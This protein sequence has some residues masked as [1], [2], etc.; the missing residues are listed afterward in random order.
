M[1]TAVPVIQSMTNYKQ[2]Q[3][4]VLLMD[5]NPSLHLQNPNPY[6]ISLMSTAK[7]LLSFPQLSSSLFSFKP[8]FSSLSPLLSSSR[9]SI[10]SLSLSFNPPNTTL[11]SLS[12]FLTS[13][14]TTTDK[15]SIPSSSPRAL[16]LSASLRQLVHDY[17]WD[18]IISDDGG[19]HSLS[20]TLL[21]CVKPNLVVLFSPIIRSLNGL[22]EFFDMELSDA[23]EFVDKFREVFQSV[24][25]AFVSKGIHFSWVD[26]KYETGCDDAFDESGVFESG[27]RDL[28]WGICSSDCIVL[29]SALLPFGLIYPRI[30]ISPK[31]VNFDDS[32]KPIHAQ[33]ILEILDVNGKPL[34]CKCCDLELVN[35]NIFSAITSKLIWEDFRHGIIKLHVKAVQNSEKCV[36]FDGFTLSNPVIVRELSG[37]SGGQKE[38][39][40][41]FFEDRVLEILGVQL[42]ELVP[43]KSI[44]IL[45]ILFS[46]L[47]RQDYW[48]LV[49]LSNSNGNSLEGIMKPFTVSLA[50]LSIVKFNP[51]NE[52]DGA[53]FH[54]SVMKSETKNCESKSDIS[55]SFGLVGSQFTPSPSNKDV[56]IEDSKRKK[57]KKSLNMLQE[58]TWS[59]FYKA[60]L[61]H[62]DLDLEDVYFAR[63][64]SKSKKLKF[65]RCWIKQIKKSSN[66]SL[67]ELEGS[68]LQQDIPK[69]VV[70]RL[71]KLPQECE[72][73]IASCSSV[74]EDSLSGASRIQDEVV[75][76]LCSESLES[77]LNNLPHKIQQGLESEEVDLAS[78][79]N[80]LVNS[81]IFWLYQK[82]EK[83]TMS[84]SQIHVVKSDDPSSS[85]VAL[86]LTNLLLV[87]PKDLA[88]VHKNGHRS[89][90]ASSE[91]TS[92]NIIREYELQILFRMEILQSEVGASFV[93]S[94]KQKFAKQICLLLENVQCH[95]QGDFFGDW[96]LDKYVEKIIKSRYG[97]SLG[98]V[99]E[100]IYERMD[101]LLFEDEEETANTLLNSEESSQSWREKHKRDEADENCIKNNQVSTE[102][103]PFQGAENEHQSLQGEEHARKLLEA[104][105][106]RQR[107]R[108]FASFTS[109]VPDLQ[110]VWAPKQPKAM[111]VNSDHVRK[112]S[113]RKEKGRLSYDTVCETPMSGLK[114]SCGRGGGSSGEKDYQDTGSSL[115]GSVSKALFQDD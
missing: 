88:T 67:T 75:M 83:E 57:T 29:G 4:I 53:G 82:Y 71:T 54:Q 14:L 100:K 9:L 31:F 63:G 77:F 86:Q 74:A 43:R 44:P 28:G 101:L 70:N 55:H 69:E 19:D 80:R 62:F 3:R 108:R 33:L 98:D 20:G 68:K 39:C 25:D 65:L 115:R 46:F 78:L 1:A 12:H 24:N 7:T 81:S 72:Q 52:F 40:S 79:A 42:G 11:D 41:E 21:N 8:F 35:L 84:E 110:R 22:C 30:G 109:W 34:E 37:V 106:R 111:K 2:T 93:E 103:E 61:D 89:S 104:Q 18:S 36:K 113:K 95:L 97:Q 92:E 66:C 45:Q 114:R 16:H 17:A 48:A 32:L 76:G 49:S 94:T 15:V 90:H 60:A 59:A 5:L 96:S 10:P 13:L 85:I 99:V 112:F 107:A 87:D 64:C 47:Y 38:S 50:L 6:L 102:E 23:D 56:E 73:P 105:Q 51:N 58:L 27:I 91:A 26:V